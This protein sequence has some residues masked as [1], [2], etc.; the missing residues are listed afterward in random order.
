MHWRDSIRFQLTFIFLCILFLVVLVGSFSIWRLSGFNDLSADVSEVWL[1]STRVIGDLNNFTSDFR[2]IEGSY[3]LATNSSEIDPIFK[4]MEGLDRSISE[5][6]T[7]F[8][9]IRHNSKEAELYADFKRQW[10]RYREIVDHQMGLVERGDTGTAV[11]NYKN[12]SRRSYDA[13]SDTLGALTDQ[14]VSSAQ[15]AKDR[16]VQKCILAHL[17]CDI[18]CRP[19]CGGGA[20]LHQTLRLQAPCAIDG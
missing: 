8:E 9:A 6:E 5:A 16:C 20:R 3:L 1:P 15:A 7:R 4:E 10:I 14:I 13:A 12:S 11:V 2:A 18:G 17:W 19:A